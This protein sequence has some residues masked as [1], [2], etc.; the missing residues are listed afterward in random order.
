MFWKTRRVCGAMSPATRL[1]VA[2]SMGTWPETNSRLPALMACEYGPDRRRADGVETA[3]RIPGFGRR[4]PRRRSRGPAA[5]LRSGGRV[6]RLA[7]P[8]AACMKARRP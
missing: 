1:P 3:C 4:T 2:G 5:P 7:E 8:V 6:P